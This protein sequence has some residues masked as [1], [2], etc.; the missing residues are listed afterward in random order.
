MLLKNDGKLL[1]LGPECVA[2]SSS[3]ATPT[4][5]C[6]PAA[7]RRWSIRAAA[8]RCRASRRRPGPGRSMYYPSSPL[9]AI[10]AACAAGE[11]HASSTATIPRRPQPRRERDVAIVFA[12]PMV[13]RR[14]RRARLSLTGNQDALIDAV[15]AANPRTAVVLETGGPRAD[16]L[17]A[18]V[19]AIL[20][21]W[22]PGPRRRRGDRQ[23]AVR[24]GESVG[25]FAGHLPAASKASFRARCGPGGKTE[26]DEFPLPYTEGA[27][28]GYKWFDKN[29]LQPLF[30]F[31][32]GLSYTRFELGQPARSA[33]ADGTV[34]VDFHGPQ[35]RPA[36]RD[37]RSPRSMLA[38]ERRMGSARSD[39][40]AFQ[41]VDLAPGASQ[42]VSVDDR[43]AP[44]RNIRRRGAAMA[45]RA[46]R[47]SN[48]GRCIVARH[49]PV[50]PTTVT[51]A[52]ALTLP[53]NWRPGPAAAAPAPQRGERGR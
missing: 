12:H 19:P 40:A 15:A 24:P 14:L 46:R 34:T 53:S 1:P 38:G 35:H 17:G 25:P 10:C 16:A 21:A 37:G 2:S 43:S 27:A 51:S 42:T 11:G 23:R 18:R 30:P 7:A 13:G 41:K 29:N 22:Y 3:A 45:D 26:E 50:R 33:N 31:G 8:M 48:P 4:R 5:A 36:S 49:P 39:S 6:S 47:L 32:H 9:K 52:G 44:A 20:E 28:V